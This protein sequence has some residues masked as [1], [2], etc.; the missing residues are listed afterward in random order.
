MSADLGA[1]SPTAYL[2]GISLDDRRRSGTVYTPQHLAAFILDQ[3]GY[4]DDKAL[5]R[6]PILDPACGAGVFLC[7]AL[8]RAASHIGGGVLPLPRT[9]RRA[10]IQFASRNLFGID[11]DPNARVLTLAALK[12]VLQEVAPGPLPDS[13]FGRN[14]LVNDFLVGDELARLPPVRQGGFAFIVGNPPYVSTVRLD[15]PYKTSLRTLF[16]TAVG[17][18]DLYTLFFERALGMLRPE[19]TMGFISPDKFLTSETS[20]RLRSF[21]LSQG[22]IRTVA[23]FRSHR[24]FPGAA[25]VPCITVIDKQSRSDNVEVL[26]CQTD[27]AGVRVAR[28]SRVPKHELGEGAWDFRPP[29]LLRIVRRLQ[30]AFPSLNSLSNRISAGPATGRDD[31]YVRPM[32][33]FASVEPEL[34]RPAVRGRDIG[35]FTIS[36]PGLGVLLPFTF[37]RGAPRLIS[38]DRYPGA[39]RYLEKHRSDLE[40]RH[41][42]RVWGKSWFDIHDLPASDIA[43]AAKILVPDVAERCRFAVDR[44]QFF[45]L[46][47]AYYI[48]PHEPECL[49]YL[50]AVLNSR[51]VEFVVRLRAPV[52]KDGFSRFRRQFLASIP[53][54][55][56]T[57]SE[58]SLIERAA[59]LRD[60]AE[61]NDRIARIY[62]LSNSELKRVEDHLAGLNSE[63]SK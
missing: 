44:G 60:V 9:K 54:A 42:V 35:A 32:S 63:A 34:I 47:S 39:F 43:R 13:L 8:R 24:V 7:E 16:S 49:D 37:S 26:T 3:V 33:D 45:P 31:V 55:T 23:R 51:I 18:V 48:V 12:E 25:V 50:T 38:P 36:N 19:G 46:H 2:E 17:R 14:I 59:D 21:I 52:A 11:T 40:P 53:I 22:S 27:G 61:L 1:T 5:E 58:A 15:G 29:E 4:T 56:G 10:F 57:A 30:S 41:C 6:A 62:G 20:R 28:R